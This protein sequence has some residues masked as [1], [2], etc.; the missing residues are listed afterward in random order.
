MSD[1][2][3]NQIKKITR[4][5]NKRI[6]FNEFR[7]PYLEAYKL[8]NEKIK[9][10]AKEGKNT[11][12]FDFVYNKEGIDKS[13]PLNQIERLESRIYL[14]RKEGQANIN[15]YDYPSYLISRGFNVEVGEESPESSHGY[16]TKTYVISW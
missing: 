7:F 5:A 13:M 9:E 4:R 11:I 12:T 6:N 10:A 8:F 15:V 2:N 16:L 1:I 3:L 14:L